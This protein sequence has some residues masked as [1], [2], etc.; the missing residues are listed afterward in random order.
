VSRARALALLGAIAC[1]AGCGSSEPSGKIHG[2]RLTVYYSGPTHGPSSAGSL[3]ALD[4]AQ[5][6]LDVV[7]G[8]IGKYRI[9]LRA[10]DDAA[11]QKAGWEPSQT[12]ND[13][14]IAVQ[15][16]TTVGYIG[17]FNSGAA[18]ISIPL[19][20]RQGVAQVSPAASSVGLTSAGPGASPGEPQKYYPSGIRTFA[21]PVPTDATEALVQVRLAQSRGCRRMFVLHDGEVDGEDEAL[22]FVLTAQSAG[23]RVVGVQ[24]FQP[25]TADYG[26]LALSI[27]QTGTDCVL[28]SAI[29]ERSAA[30]LTNQLAAAMPHAAMIASSGLADSN[31]TDPAAGGVSAR[32]S[33]RVLITSPAVDARAYPASGQAFLAA[34]S[35]RF[36]PPEP[37]AIFGYEAMSLLLSAIT[38]TTDHG[39]KTAVRSN[40]I[41]QIF[42]TRKRDS[43]LGVYSIDRQGDATLRRYGIWRIAGGRLTF[44]REAG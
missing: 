34:Y 3:A 29:A 31:Y 43:V 14:R 11:P 27:A 20:N 10:L 18:A 37:P 44:V 21:R 24:A 12:T 28:L 23:L 7:H 32:V 9:E 1:L 38:R 42:A 8:R 36:G 16:P 39:R 13:V 15:D 22:S 33:P 5:M 2:T 6:A 40:V 25:L 26:P 35:R 17:D 30:R 4:G 41:K 19:L